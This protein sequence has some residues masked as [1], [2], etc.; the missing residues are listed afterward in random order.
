MLIGL[1]WILALSN[2]MADPN[3]ELHPVMLGTVPPDLEMFVD[4]IYKAEGGK[5]TDKPYGEIGRAHV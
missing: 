4:A 1:T 5:K 2:L 3:D